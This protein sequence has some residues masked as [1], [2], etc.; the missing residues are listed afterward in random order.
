LVS[1]THNTERKVLLREIGE[2]FRRAYFDGPVETD[3]EYHEAV[4]HRERR[5]A[6]RKART[7]TQ[8]QM[9][10]DAMADLQAA[11]DGYNPNG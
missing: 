9:A 4:A 11:R 6:E 7:R 8:G 10:D 3:A 1:V 2:T 5:A